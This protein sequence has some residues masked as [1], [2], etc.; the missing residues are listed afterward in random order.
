MRPSK[1]ISRY[2]LLGLIGRG[3]RRR[4]RG[5]VGGALVEIKEGRWNYFY[6]NL[7][8]LFLGKNHMFYRL[9]LN[10]DAMEKYTL[11][12]ILFRVN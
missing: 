12:L 5:E 2:G 9:H 11:N 10:L 3:C 8:Y 7:I 1:S 4:G 6:L